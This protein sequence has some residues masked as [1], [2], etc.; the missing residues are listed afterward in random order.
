MPIPTGPLCAG[1][2][3]TP[4]VA[5]PIELKPA[6]WYEPTPRSESRLLGASASPAHLWQPPRHFQPQPVDAR[7]GSDEES[8]SIRI[9][10]RAVGR[11]LGQLN[12]SQVFPFRRDDQNPSR[13]G[14]VKVAIFVDFHSVRHT[15]ARL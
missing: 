2:W 6:L 5:P 12:G 11:D 9:A 4:P 10:K 3:G 14:S 13:T 1:F 7:A 15:F 8:L